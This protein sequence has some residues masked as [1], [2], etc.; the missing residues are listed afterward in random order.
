M[1]ALTNNYQRKL[2]SMLSDPSSDDKVKAALENQILQNSILKLVLEKI[3]RKVDSQV[4]P[5]KVSRTLFIDSLQ[6]DSIPNENQ[7]KA[8]TKHIA[9]VQHLLQ[10][11]NRIL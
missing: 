6:T 4:D 3:P 9:Q 1:T 8:Q 7:I 5:F 2:Q 11:L 10:V